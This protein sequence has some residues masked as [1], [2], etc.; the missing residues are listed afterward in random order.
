MSSKCDSSERHVT[1][2]AMWHASQR[3]CFGEL[4]VDS[5]YPTKVNPARDWY[6]MP[7]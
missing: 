7:Y 3:K 4:D 5:T 6:S 1:L 2:I